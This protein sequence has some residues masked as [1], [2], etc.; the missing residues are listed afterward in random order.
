MFQFQSDIKS[1]IYCS[2]NWY[3]QCKKQFFIDARYTGNSAKDQNDCSHPDMS[4]FDQFAKLQWRTGQQEGGKANHPLRIKTTGRD[5]VSF[6]FSEKYN[7]KLN[8]ESMCT[9]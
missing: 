3:S 6:P 9:D 8:F 2:K 5:T 4:R 1:S 7:S